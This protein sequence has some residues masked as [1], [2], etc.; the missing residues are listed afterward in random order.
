M[1]LNNHP[2]E[3][4]HTKAFPLFSQ[5][6]EGNLFVIKLLSMPRLEMIY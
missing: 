6:L 5:V 3:I 1:E 4:R 2:A